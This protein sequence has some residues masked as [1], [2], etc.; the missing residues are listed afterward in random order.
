M[1]RLWTGYLTGGTSALFI[2]LSAEALG[3][4]MTHAAVVWIVV[5]P[6]GIMLANR[7]T[8]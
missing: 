1:D 7:T 5:T 2:G 8:K 6:F 4:S 3:M